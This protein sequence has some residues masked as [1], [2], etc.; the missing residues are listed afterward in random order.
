MIKCTGY[1]TEPTKEIDYEYFERLGI[2]PPEPEEPLMIETTC[3]IDI[4]GIQA[5]FDTQDGK[6]IIY[7]LNDWCISIKK[8]K[9]VLDQLI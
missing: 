8:E 9:S 4:K 6:V 1:Y 7:Y 2:S 5:V 3:W